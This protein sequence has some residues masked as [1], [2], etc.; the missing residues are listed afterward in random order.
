VTGVAAD[1]EIE[2][3]HAVTAGDGADRVI[4]GADREMTETTAEI[5]RVGIGHAVE[6]G[7]TVDTTTAIDHE[8][9]RETGDRP[10]MS[11]LTDVMS[12]TT[13]DIAVVAIHTE[14]MTTDRL[15][16]FTEQTA[17]SADW[18]CMNQCYVTE[19]HNC[20]LCRVFMK[21]TLTRN[22]AVADKLHDTTD[23]WLLRHITAFYLSL[24]SA[25]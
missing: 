1:H 18:C 15:S 5:V 8:R 6:T 19:I 12:E 4:V 3:L 13:T 23:A 21:V 22:S 9:D 16:S 10:T 24:L 2:T 11:R 25:G 7:N 17:Y 14:M 20:V